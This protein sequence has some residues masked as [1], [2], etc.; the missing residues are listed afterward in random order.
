MD[1]ESG[2]RWGVAIALLC[3]L[4][5][6]LLSRP[7][8][9]RSLTQACVGPPF[10]MDRLLARPHPESLKRARNPRFPHEECC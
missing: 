6:A 3:V 7:G 2:L 8:T 9:E 10:P 4:V 5:V 1:R